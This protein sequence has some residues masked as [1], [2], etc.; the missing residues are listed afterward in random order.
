MLSVQISNGAKI[1]SKVKFS[2]GGL[3]VVINSGCIIEDNVKIGTG[4]LLGGRELAPGKVP[5]IKRN[6]IIST[7][8]KI[9]GPVTVGENSVIGANS[10]VISDVP[11]N[12]IVAGIPGKVIKY[13]IDILEYRDDI[14]DLEK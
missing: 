9:L 6:S 3:G 4:V 7:G 2:Y 10:V 5:V 1:G 13:N 12:S 14:S 8:A 11:P